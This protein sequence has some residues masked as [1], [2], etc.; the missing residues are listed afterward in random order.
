MRKHLLLLAVIPATVLA[1]AIV[2]ADAMSA[3]EI[4]ATQASDPSVSVQRLYEEC[5]GS[6][7]AQLYCSAYI[8]G[9]AESMMV[10]GAGDSS[11]RVFGI[12]PKAAMTPAAAMQAFKSWAEQHPE[13]WGAFRYLGVAFALK[14][15]WPCS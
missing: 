15:H 4:A 6:K 10:A 12:C 9:T 11:A 8:T 2:G 14:E 5:T 7:V 1:S 3:R 13:A